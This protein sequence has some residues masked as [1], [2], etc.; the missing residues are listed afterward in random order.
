PEF[1]SLNVLFALSGYEPVITDGCDVKLFALANAIAQIKSL[2]RGASRQISLSGICVICRQSRVG[3]RKIRIEQNRAF[4]KRYG[5][6]V[7]A[8]KMIIEPQRISFERF[9]RWRRRLF[10]RRIELLNRSQRFP[11][12]LTQPGCRFANFLN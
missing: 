2:L 10:D 11:K 12:P 8:F 9:E 4:E 7:A 6:R 5:V 3:D 1:Q